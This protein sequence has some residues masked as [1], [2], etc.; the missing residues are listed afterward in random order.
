MASNGPAGSSSFASG[1]ATIG[2]NVI[3]V[4]PCFTT[5]IPQLAFNPSSLFQV[6]DGATGSI[7]FVR[8]VNGVE[9]STGVPLI[10]GAYAFLI[11]QD[12]SDTALSSAWVSTADKANTPGTLTLNVDTTVDATLLTT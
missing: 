9:T 11:Y 2:F 5:T 8:P 3:I 4:N 12:T 10:C 6:T 1:G 7:D